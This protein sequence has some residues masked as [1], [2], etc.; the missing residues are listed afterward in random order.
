MRARTK[1]TRFQDADRNLRLFTMMDSLRTGGSERHFDLLAGAFRRGPF[2]FCIQRCGKFLEDLGEI[3]EQ[4]LG[5]SSV[6]GCT[7][8]SRIDDRRGVYPG[9]LGDRG[10]AGVESN[11]RGG[12]IESPSVRT[13]RTED[14]F[15]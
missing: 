1:A 11:G 3:E 4:P 15:L 6:D 8:L 2:D 5:F 9:K 14:A 13:R 10:G 12:S 7:T